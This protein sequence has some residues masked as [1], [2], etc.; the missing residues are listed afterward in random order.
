MFTLRKKESIETLSLEDINSLI[1]TEFNNLRDE[2]ST[3][4]IMDEM[5]KKI[6]THVTN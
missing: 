5:S 6:I 1:L 3:E 2:I 4:K